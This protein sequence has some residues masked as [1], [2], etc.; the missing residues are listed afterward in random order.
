MVST[1]AIQRIVLVLL[2]TLSFIT[3]MHATFTGPAKAAQSVNVTISNLAFNPQNVTIKVGSTITWINNDPLIYTLWF[4]KAD[5]GTTYKKAGKEGLS[6]PILPDTSWSETFNEIINLKYHSLERLWITGFITIVPLV[7]PTASFTYSPSEPEIGQTVTFNASNSIDPDSNIVS[8]YWNFSDGTA[9]T[10]TDPIAY[11]VFGASGTYNVTLTVTD[12]DGLTDSEYKLITVF[13]PP[14]ATFTYLPTVPLVG[15]TVTFDASQSVDADGIIQSYFWSFDDG[16]T[17]TETDAFATHIY[18]EDGTYNVTLTVTDDDGLSDSTWETVAVLPIHDVAVISV[19]PS[20]TKVTI[21]ENVTI[22]VDFKNEGTVA[23][24]FTVTAYSNNTAIDTKT[25]TSL[26]ADSSDTLDFVWDTTDADEG[27]YVIKAEASP[28]TG[29][30]DI[31]DNTLTSDEMIT[32][33]PAPFVIFPYI[34]IALVII[35]IVVVS[36]G[37][38]FYL[39]RKRSR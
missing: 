2:L 31:A 29:E 1:K 27:D 32:I 35:A 8:Y 28:V 33:K 24:T 7:P 9:T 18:S 20:S 19:T 16:I 25:V 23:E 6:D 13:E 21:G 11:H 22:T 14:V 26:P 38:Y 39:R 30:T 15:E 17:I 34:G 36:V 37:A 10:E 3:T 12:E 5:D 4:V